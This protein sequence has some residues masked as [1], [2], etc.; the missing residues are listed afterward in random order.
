MR[1]GVPEDILRRKMHGDFAGA[2]RLI[3]RRLQDPD[4]PEALRGS[5]LIQ[6]K[7]CRELPSEFPYSKDD[8]LAI[9]RKDIPDF[10]EAEFEELV[11]QR[12]IRWIYVNGEERYFNR[13]YSSLCKAVPEFSRRARQQ[14]GGMESLSSA[15]ATANLRDLIIAKM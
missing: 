5:L 4:L 7:I 9:I 10:T 15:S 8:A 13:F 2:I 12:N 6:K 3:D 11:D 14:I 1:Y